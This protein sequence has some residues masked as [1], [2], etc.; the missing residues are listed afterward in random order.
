MAN[1]ASKVVN[2]TAAEEPSDHRTRFNRKKIP[3]INLESKKKVITFNKG[4]SYGNNIENDNYTDCDE[5]HNKDN[6]KDDNKD[7]WNDDDDN[8]KNDDSFFLDAFLL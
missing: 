5:D 8:D 3:N 2:G 1:K 7:H 4:D 6:D